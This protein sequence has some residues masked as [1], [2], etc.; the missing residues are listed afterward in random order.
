MQMFSRNTVLMLMVVS[1]TVVSLGAAS[2]TS[3]LLE[4]TNAPLEAAT[5]LG[6]KPSVILSKK[7][8]QLLTVSFQSMSV[9]VRDLR[10]FSIRYMVTIPDKY[11]VTAS[12]H[13]TV[14][15]GGGPVEDEGQGYFSID[16]GDDRISFFTPA[17]SFSLEDKDG[18]TYTVV[19]CFPREKS[20]QYSV[21]QIA[22]HTF[23]VNRQGIP[24]KLFKHNLGDHKVLFVK[25]NFLFPSQDLFLARVTT[26]YATNL[27]IEEIRCLF[28]TERVES[29]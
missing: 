11:K 24:S 25:D 17:I 8:N 4:D 26:K 20:K 7:G 6:A 22:P 16:G 28:P 12:K 10:S 1:Q 13:I 29:W 27:C 9:D 21:E 19:L 23:L 3:L 15:A 18:T 14:N 2:Q 5:V